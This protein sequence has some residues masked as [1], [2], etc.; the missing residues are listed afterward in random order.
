MDRRDF[1]KTAA[2]AP[3]A[4][5]PLVQGIPIEKAPEELTELEKA[6]LWEKYKNL[7]HYCA[8]KI[9]H[10]PVI[11]GGE[12]NPENTKVG[13]QGEWVTF[14]F[15]GTKIYSS[16]DDQVESFREVIL[17][18]A[19]WWRNKNLGGG[20]FDSPGFSVFMKETIW[21]HA[22]DLLEGYR[23]GIDYPDGS[24]ADGWEDRCGSPQK[25]VNGR[26]QYING[27]WLPIMEFDKDAYRRPRMEKIKEILRDVPWVPTEGAEMPQCHKK[28][29]VYV[30][31]EEAVDDMGSNSVAWG[32]MDLYVLEHGW[33]TLKANE[34]SYRQMFNSRY[35]QYEELRREKT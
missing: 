35:S 13:K 33:S 34:N 17:D 16:H 18:A 32:E 31:Q 10:D 5:L 29:T 27:R 24:W 26:W 23:E 21:H 9:R 4:G 8:W 12:I 25:H 7:V 1:V 30:R 20:K 3:I 22:K 15:Q 2:V 14:E 11:Y 28:A 19:Q 6:Q